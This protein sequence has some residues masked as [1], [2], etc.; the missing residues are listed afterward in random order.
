MLRW[1]LP[2][3]LVLLAALA[4]CQPGASSPSG[5]APDRTEKETPKSTDTG[6]IKPPNPDPG[7]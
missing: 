4:G 3:V 2:S 5:K 7:K 6:G 1:S